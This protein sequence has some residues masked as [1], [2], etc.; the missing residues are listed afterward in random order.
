MNCQKKKKISLKFFFVG[1]FLLISLILFVIYFLTKSFSET[2]GTEQD[3]S[4]NK[5]ETSELSKPGSQKPSLGSENEGIKLWWLTDEE[6]NF[7]YQEIGS[8]PEIKL[9][10]PSVVQ[11][12][13]EGKEIPEDLKEAKF[14]FLPI[15]NSES[16]ESSD[17][18][19][20][21]TL[22]VYMKNSFASHYNSLGSSIPA[23][24]KKVVK[25][26]AKNLERKSI[27]ICA[28]PV[29]QQTNGSDC[30][31]YVIAFTRVLLKYFEENGSILL[32]IKEKD[33][34]FTIKEERK[35][36]MKAG[37]P[38]QGSAGGNYDI[39]DDIIYLESE[40]NR[41]LK[42]W[43]ELQTP[44]QKFIKEEL[45]LF[46][47]AEK[48]HEFSKQIR[49][50]SGRN[51]EKKLLKK[52]YITKKILKFSSFPL[53]EYKNTTSLTN[54]NDKLGDKLNDK[55]KSYIREYLNK[56]F[57]EKVNKEYSAYFNLNN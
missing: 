15:N 48:L 26:L 49:L 27:P 56:E 6:I 36:L 5:N 55:E 52:I 33:F 28:C 25:Q 20:H 4:A 11:A 51:L 44:I 40:E 24:A 17:S 43:K 57:A 30:G 23:N 38:K 13:K 32:N 9:V 22:L 12:I 31:L 37:F 53:A 2:K 46:D 47:K 42:W 54:K 1:F 14:V 35:R 7:V 10:E 8:L 29:A 3:F 50:L 21:W 41:I 16:P 39:G 19:S 18:G 45:G 34:L